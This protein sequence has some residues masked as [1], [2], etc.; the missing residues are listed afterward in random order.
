MKLFFKLSPDL[1]PVP[2]D[3]QTLDWMAKRKAGEIISADVKLSRNYEQHK[4]FFSF[5]NKTFDMQEHFDNF[6]SYR[7]WIT[8]KCGYYTPIVCP[9]GN[10]IFVAE[11][12]SFDNMDEEK[13]MTLFSSAIDVFLAEFGKGIDEAE[14]MRVI[15]YG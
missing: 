8:M 11:S 6:E 10:T 13:F 14:L 9:N 7:K 3:Q 12:I 15:D 5:L 2:H 1:E 4:R